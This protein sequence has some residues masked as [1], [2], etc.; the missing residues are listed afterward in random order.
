[1]RKTHITYTSKQCRNPSV[2]V[3]NHD[4][5]QKQRMKKF[6]YQFC[7]DQ[8]PT[9]PVQERRGKREWFFRQWIEIVDRACRFGPLREGRWRWHI[10][11]RFCKSLRQL[12]RTIKPAPMTKMPFPFRSS[13]YFG[14][15]RFVGALFYGILYYIFSIF[16]LFLLFMTASIF[17]IFKLAYNILFLVDWILPTNF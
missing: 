5:T 11:T 10:Y 14:V 16:N 13:S 8:T 15:T 7:W 9:K 4:Y 2:F 1:M 12:R 3:I 17:T 6:T